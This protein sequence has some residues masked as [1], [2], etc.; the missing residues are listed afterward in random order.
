MDGERQKSIRKKLVTALFQDE[1]TDLGKLWTQHTALTDSEWE[2]VLNV[3]TLLN[4]R[5]SQRYSALLSAPLAFSL[6]YTR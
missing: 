2:R 4:L 6:T 1:S 5:K 3:T